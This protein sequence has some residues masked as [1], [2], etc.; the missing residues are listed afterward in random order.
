[1]IS[2][3]IYQKSIKIVTQKNFFFSIAIISKKIQ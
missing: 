3:M 1:M 2:Y